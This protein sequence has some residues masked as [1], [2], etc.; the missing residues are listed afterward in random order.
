MHTNKQNNRNE[1]LIPAGLLFLSAVPVL[2]G[3]VRLTQL[4]G[5]AE[6]T[7]ENA[8]FF[9]APLPVVLHIVSVTLYSMLGAF[10]FA[11]GFRRQRRRWHRVAGRL[12]IPSGLVA[13]LSGLWMT[14]FYPWPQYDGELLYVMRLLVGVVMVLALGVGTTAI[15]RRNFAEHGAW[16]LRAYALGMGAGTQVFTHLPWFLLPEMH[17]ELFRVLCMGAGWVI[18]IIIAEWIIRTRIAPRK[19]RYSAGQL[20]PKGVQL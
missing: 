11:P 14:L 2:A 8:R 18:N 7:A 17:G 13:A 1:W 5:G 15:R 16:M 6:I 9:A 20:N 4:A 3:S 19:R 10:Q 12:L